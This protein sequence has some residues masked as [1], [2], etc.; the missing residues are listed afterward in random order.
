[1]IRLKKLAFIT[2]KRL[3]KEVGL[4]DVYEGDNIESGKKSYALYFILRDDEK[5]LTDEEI[6]QT[7]N[8]LIK[9]Y[10]EKLNAHVR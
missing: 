4:F 9:V 8:R 5:T 7:M 2:E 10:T 3:L 6:D 1:M